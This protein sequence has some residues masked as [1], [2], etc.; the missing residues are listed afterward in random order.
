M[1]GERATAA[2]Q[3]LGTIALV[4][5]PQTRAV[6]P[7]AVLAVPPGTRQVTFELRLESSPLPR[8]QVA[9]KDPGTSQIVW[10]SG[11]VAP[12]PGEP[13]SVSVTVPAG[14]MKPQHYALD[15]VGQG[16]DGTRQVVGSYAVQIVGG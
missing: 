11:P 9:V 5:L 12:S 14:V 3:A 15:L 10:R 13:L 2:S 8:Y 1:P 16:A 7:I 6:G 4:L